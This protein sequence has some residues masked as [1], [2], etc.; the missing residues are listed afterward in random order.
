MSVADSKMENTESPVPAPVENDSAVKVEESQ[1]AIDTPTAST[2]APAPAAQTPNAQT[3]G[4]EPAPA[5]VGSLAT[6]NGVTKDG[7]TVMDNV[8]RHMSDYRTPEYVSWRWRICFAGGL[9]MDLQWT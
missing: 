8:V 3:P 1:P 2:P 5:S 7:Y 9:L 6:V 4:P